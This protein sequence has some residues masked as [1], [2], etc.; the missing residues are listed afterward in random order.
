M[1]ERKYSREY[2]VVFVPA[3]NNRWWNGFLNKKICHCFLVTAGASGSVTINTSV[4]GI[5]VQTYK[6]SM[7]NIAISCLQ[8]GYKVLYKKTEDMN[9]PRMKFF[10]SCVGVTKDML[11]INN[12]MI[13]TA[14]QLYNY[15]GGKDV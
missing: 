12:L 9:K 5:K 13:I 3:N 2:Y 4:G 7:E 1:E 6:E 14:K 15:L 8:K 10:R 11:G